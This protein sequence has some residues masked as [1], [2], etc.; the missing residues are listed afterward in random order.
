MSEISPQ[1]ETIP[2]DFYQAKMLVS[3]LRLN[4][5]KIDCCL[6]VCML[7][8]KDDA[9]LTHYK[10]C[11]EPKF[12]PKRAGSVAYKDV[13][14]KR[15]HYLPLIP[16]LKRLYSS[17]SSTPY[18]MWHF[19]N[20]KN[21]D[22]MTHPS[23]GKAWQYFDRTYSN[24]ASDPLNIRLR[25]CTDSLIN[26]PTISPFLPLFLYFYLLYFYVFILFIIS[27]SFFFKRMSKLGVCS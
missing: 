26:C 4:K 14:H 23:H 16:R 17:M 24:F 13:P 20:R 10:F 27:I 6:N 9:A 19:E 11:G 21:D 5:V 12:K 1:P 7:Y 18:K 8:H 15:M 22:V 25:L 3:K 2:K